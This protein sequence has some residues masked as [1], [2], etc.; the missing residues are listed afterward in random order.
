[1]D[2]PLQQQQHTL[3][4]A[5]TAATADTVVAPV[6]TIQYYCRHILKIVYD[7]EQDENAAELWWADGG[8]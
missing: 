6:P 7:G 3:V 5:A 2:A 4:T 1:M 8:R